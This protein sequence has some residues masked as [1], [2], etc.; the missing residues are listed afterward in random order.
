M[1][2]EADRDLGVTAHAGGD[3]GLHVGGR[4]DA[5]GA[6]V[7]RFDGVERAVHWAT[8]TLVLTLIVTGSLMY[9]GALGGLVGR[10][11]LVE[12]IHLIAGLAVPVPIAV[13]LAGRWG[14]GLRRDLRRLGRFLDDDLL[15]LRAR[16]R[17]SGRLR[18]G[19]FNG[20]QKLNAVLVGA[21]LPVMFGTGLLLHW[22][23]ALPDRYRTGA[24]F[25]HDWGYLALAQLV[26]GHIVTALSDPVALSAMLRGRVPRRWVREE[27]PRWDDELDA[28]DR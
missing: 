8:A 2:T 13:A 25:V 9:I 10:R 15:W 12:R 4:S 21:A 5:D 22:A 26:A 20:G 3:A 17:R 14:R 1:T 19:K 27:H 24:T 23:T 28:G 6:T 18:I 11:A 7:L 16:H